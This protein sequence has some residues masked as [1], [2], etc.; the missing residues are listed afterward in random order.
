MKLILV[1]SLTILLALNVTAS[2]SS[3]QELITESI[4]LWTTI[5]K[6]WYQFQTKCRV[7]ILEYL[8]EDDLGEKLADILKIYVRRLNARLDQRLSREE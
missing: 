7:K 1:I 5:R 8:H 2:K 6:L 3:Q 4:K